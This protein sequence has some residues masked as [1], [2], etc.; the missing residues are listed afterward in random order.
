MLK[1]CWQYSSQH[2][3]Y[4][5]TSSSGAISDH[6]QYCTDPAPFSRVKAGKNQL[7]P[8]NRHWLQPEDSGSQPPE[9]II[10]EF[11]RLTLPWSMQS[12]AHPVPLRT[13][14]IQD[15]HVVWGREDCSAFC[16]PSY[17]CMIGSIREL[18]EAKSSCSLPRRALRLP[19]LL[20]AHATGGH[21]PARRTEKQPFCEAV[22]G[23]TPTPD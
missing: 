4:P 22:L 1:L 14:S 19:V 10:L 15:T 13:F 23:M 2:D 5:H 7:C 16:A 12:K 18:Y 3:E 9:H 6:R 17:P 8:P 20:R 21:K 11:K